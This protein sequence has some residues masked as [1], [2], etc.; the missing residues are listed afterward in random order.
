VEHK[1]KEMKYFTTILIVLFFFVNTYSQFLTIVGGGESDSSTLYTG[2]VAAWGLN[3][4]SGPDVYDYTANNYDGT[5]INTPTFGATGKVD[6]AI[7]FDE[8]SSELIDFG[9]SFWDPGTSDLTVAVWISLTA[10]SDEQGVVGNWG[11]DPYWYIRVSPSDQIFAI[12]NFTGSNIE[13]T[14]NGTIA[15]DGTW[16][17][18]IYQLDRDGN[19]SLYLNNALQSDQDD[20][21]AHSAVNLANANR[22]AIGTIGNNIAGYYWDGAIDAVQVWSRL[23]TS[24]ER[25]ELYNSGNGW[26]P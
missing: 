8:G 21:S 19:A 17:H 16:Y 15:T 2:L 14:S 20:I 5:A 3:E 23:L 6:D 26:E 25:T 1:K 10:S 11:S 4:A 12:V 24:D 13:T 9:T 7:S 22:Q 18:L